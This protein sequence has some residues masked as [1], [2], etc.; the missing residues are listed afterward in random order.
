MFMKGGISV[1]LGKQIL[2]IRK[3]NKMSQE[4]FAEIF[5]VSRQTISSWEN[6]KSY[7]DIETLIKISNKFQISLD[8]LIKGDEKMVKTIDN[9]VKKSKILIKIIIAFFLLIISSILIF[10]FIYRDRLYYFFKLPELGVVCTYDHD[11]IDYS[12]RYYK[13]SNRPIGGGGT[14]G[15]TE[16]MRE[17][18]RIVNKIKIGDFKKVEDQAEYVKSVYE[19][20]GATCKLIYYKNTEDYIN[21]IS[22][23]QSDFQD[24]LNSN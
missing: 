12:I 21:K 24:S 5:N 23:L 11:F 19:Q 18:T 17:A 9:Q 8:I 14:V 2:K 13:I 16:A 15:Q 7:P 4:E 6:S 1:N 20:K 10:Y 3:D 22:K